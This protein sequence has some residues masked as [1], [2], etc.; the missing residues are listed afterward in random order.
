MTNLTFAEAAPLLDEMKLKLEGLRP[1]P[2][3]FYPYLGRVLGQ[4]KEIV[5]PK[6]PMTINIAPEN[7]YLLRGIT[8]PAYTITIEEP[9]KNANGDEMWFESSASESFLRFGY[10]NNDPRHISSLKLDMEYIR[11]TCSTIS[12]ISTKC[13]ALAN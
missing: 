3:F 4:Q 10:E 7:K 2:I 9:I 8:D 5:K 12:S 13:G 1:A 6:Y 11:A